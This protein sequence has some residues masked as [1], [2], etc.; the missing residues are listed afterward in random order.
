MQTPKRHLT[1]ATEDVLKSP[2]LDALGNK[3]I[4]FWGGL[5]LNLNNVMGPAMVAL[6]YLNQQVAGIMSTCMRIVEDTRA[7]LSPVLFAQAGWLSCTL[8]IFVCCILSAFSCTMICD[9]AQRIPGNRNFDGYD[10]LT[11]KRY[12]LGSGPI[13]LTFL[14]V[15]VFCC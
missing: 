1:T 8:M 3:T 12:S 11:G 6:P 15:C 14:C 9:A 5:I 10:P 13:V 2:S 4:T 7:H